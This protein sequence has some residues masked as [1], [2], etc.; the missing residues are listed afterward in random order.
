MK[1]AMEMVDRQLG[2]QPTNF[3]EG[4][5]YE[6]RRVSSI[7][8]AVVRDEEEGSLQAGNQTF[9]WGSST[10]SSDHKSHKGSGGGSSVMRGVTTKST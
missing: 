4:I 5:E 8:V 6:L 9:L 2:A 10:S 1:A 3:T 7:K